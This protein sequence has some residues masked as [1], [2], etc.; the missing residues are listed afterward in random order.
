MIL[1]NVLSS[2]ILKGIRTIKTKWAKNIV[3]TSKQVNQFGIDGVAPKGCI[4][5]VSETLGNGEQVTIGYI[6]KKALTQLNV[7]DSCIYSTNDSGEVQST[8]IMRNDGTAELLGN[9]DNLVRYSKLKEDLDKTNDVINAIVNSL[10]N[11]TT[12]PSDGGAALKAYF[13]TELG[14]KVVG[15]YESSK[16]DEIKTL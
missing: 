9:T 16:I 10:K 1:V 14:I 6:N 4:A 7:G 2:S 5:V 13:L 11:W 3:E 12:A 15:T 8:I